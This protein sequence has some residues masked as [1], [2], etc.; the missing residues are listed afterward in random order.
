MSFAIEW[1][2]F[3]EGM[4]NLA[5]D[6]LNKILN[7]SS[8]DE[9]STLPEQI[10]G[11][12]IV[13]DVSFG[14]IAPELE[15]MDI[16]RMQE[17]QFE[18]KF[19]I[20]YAGDLFLELT[21]VVEVNPLVD[22]TEGTKYVS[23][24]HSEILTEALHIPLKILISKVRL[25]GII[26]ISFSKKSSGSSSHENL[27]KSQKPGPIVQASFEGDPLQSV[28]IT[29]NFESLSPVRKLLQAT[30]EDFLRQFFQTDFPN[31]VK[32]LSVMINLDD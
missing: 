17:D 9:P 2:H 12:L 31:L 4:V 7:S 20:K 8:A 3:D 24:I 15:M 28:S 10:V 22:K 11:P 5:K 14:S 27:T 18:G 32:K 6:K 13:S 25:S 19:K 21:T 30:I 26:H 16:S 23:N 1:P 29:S